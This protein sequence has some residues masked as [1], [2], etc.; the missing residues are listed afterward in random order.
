MNPARTCA[1]RCGEQI[2]PGRHFRQGH[3]AKL[4]SAALNGDQEAAA[5]IREAFPALAAQHGI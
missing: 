1:C 3:D 2:T 4:A 5:L